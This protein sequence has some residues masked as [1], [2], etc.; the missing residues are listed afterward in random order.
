MGLGLI[1]YNHYFP[2]NVLHWTAGQIYAAV[3]TLH[4][5]TPDVEDMAF[6]IAFVLSV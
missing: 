6:D 4:G 5:T 2:S 1:G 3:S